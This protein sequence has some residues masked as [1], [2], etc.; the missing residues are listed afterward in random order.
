MQA[1]DRTSPIRRV[2]EPERE[3][4]GC[5]LFPL[6]FATVLYLLVSTNCN[7][8]G[9]IRFLA[10]PDTSYEETSSMNARPASRS[11]ADCPLRTDIPTEAMQR[12]EP[13]EMPVVEHVTINAHGSVRWANTSA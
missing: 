6:C 5:S 3:R 13:G 1:R 9:H 11:K 7:F 12:N 8:A 4:P 10:V 2:I